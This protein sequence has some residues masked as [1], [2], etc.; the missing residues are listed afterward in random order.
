MNNKTITFLLLVILA[1]AAGGYWLG[2]RSI[3]NAPITT[4]SATNE[5]QPLFYRN[6]MNPEI[7]SD[8]P[9][10][11][12]MGMDYIP[13]FANNGSSNGPAGTVQIDPVT[14]QSIGVRTAKA[15]RRSMAQIIQAV[16]RIDYD[17]QRLVQLHPK[18]EGWIEKMFIE[19]TGEAVRIDTIL[20][21][22]YSPQLVSTQQEF[23]LALKN[24]KTLS[25]SPFDD[26]RT[27]A[28]ALVQTTED[29]LRLFDVPDHQIEDLKKTLTVRKDLHIHSPAKGIV[30]KIG[31]R[32]GQYVTPQTELYSIAD[33]SKVWVLVDIYEDDLPW[34]KIGDQTRMTVAAVPG[35]TFV[36]TL[37]YIYPYAESRTRTIKVRMEF[38]NPD[39]LLKPDMFADITIKADAIA[40]A[41]A[42]PSEA[43]IRSGTRQQVF[44]QRAP[45]KFEPREVSLGVSSD[46]WTQI[47]DGIE[48]G[49]KVVVSAQFLIDSESK[50]REAAAKMQEARQ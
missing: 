18:T 15:E 43:I 27:G 8:V 34:I 25:A 21:S 40:D 22:L 1:A 32:E 37:A 13:V 12:E 9:A 20:L 10:Q 7:T 46:G 44:I 42:V 33:L 24:L 30:I 50:L 41:I 23:V 3:A 16:G 35:H 39:L 26:V 28:E 4:G 29:R 36:G 17:E 6:P 48:A 31:A 2:T 45:G 11:D 38:D 5:P 47:R 14:V 49:E 19:K